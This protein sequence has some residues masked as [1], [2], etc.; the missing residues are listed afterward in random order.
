MYYICSY[1]FRFQVREELCLQE[2]ARDLNELS[3]NINYIFTYL[4]HPVDRRFGPAPWGLALDLEGLPLLHADRLGGGLLEAV[5][6]GLPD[7][8]GVGGCRSEL[9]ARVAD[10][11]PC[12]VE[13]YK[14]NP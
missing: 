4:Y 8:D 11:R 13:I 14:C 7:E 2:G 10:V 6:G 9:I 5:E 3:K 12:K 1:V